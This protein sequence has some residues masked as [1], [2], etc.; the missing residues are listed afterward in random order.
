MATYD[1]ALSRLGFQYESRVVDTHFGET[2]VLAIGLED[3]PPLVV[4]HGGN[5]LN[6]LCLSWFAPLAESYRLYSPDL[7]GQ[8]GKSAQVRPP[9]HSDGHAQ[10]SL[11]LLDA[12]DLKRVPFVGIS[13]G[14]GIALRVA[15]YAPER[16]SHAALVS[17]AGLASG[18]TW[19][20]VREVVGP[21]LLYMSSPNCERLLRAAKPILTE[22]EEPYV[23]QLGAIYRNV[24]LDTQLP[25]MATQEELTDF[26]APTLI[27]VSEEDVFFPGEVVAERAKEIVPNLVAIEALE[28]ERHVPSRQSFAYINSKIVDF[29]RNN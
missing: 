19:G 16:V 26:G 11:D 18:S 12:L 3:A 1:E 6:P 21:M 20:M 9:A 4:L 10:W 27:F 5:F 15:G 23:R 25:R 2:H 17:P 8:P 14:G 29:L 7:I 13:Y 24:K 28:G 22:L